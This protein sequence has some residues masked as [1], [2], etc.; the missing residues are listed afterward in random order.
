MNLQPV[1]SKSVY[2]TQTH[3]TFLKHHEV[4]LSNKNSKFI[5]ARSKNHVYEILNLVISVK[6]ISMG[7]RLPRKIGRCTP[8][9]AQFRAQTI[10]IPC[11]CETCLVTIWLHHH[12]FTIYI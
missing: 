8:M 1:I 5:A 4:E 12:D 10:I 9:G 3:P 6:G 2:I 7:L 11:G